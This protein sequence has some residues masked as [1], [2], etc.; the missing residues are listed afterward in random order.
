MMTS[1]RRLNLAAGSVFRTGRR[2]WET[3]KRW[4]IVA[5]STTAVLVAG[6]LASHPHH[7][8]TKTDFASG[9][10]WLPSE[11]PGQLTLLDGST[12]MIAD[13]LTSS[14]IPGTRPGDDLEVAQDGAGAY[15][16]DGAAGVIVRVD[17]TTH[18]A[19]SATSVIAPGTQAVSLY[20][21]GRY[22]YVVDETRDRVVVLNAATLREL[23]SSRARVPRAAAVV[24]GSGRL[25]LFD[26]FTGRVVELSGTHV[27]RTSLLTSP[28]DRVALA[29][30]G[31]RPAVIDYSAPH[32]YVRIA[33]ADPSGTTG[34]R[35]CIDVAAGDPSALTGGSDS[36]R[37]SVVSGTTGLIEETN[38]ANGDCSRSTTLGLAASTPTGFTPP[39][40]TA[41]RVFMG[42]EDTGQVI[43]MDPTTLQPVAPPALAVTPHS[44][45]DV[46]AKDGIVF[47]NDPGS[48]DA[49]VIR[50]D[51]TVIRV[52]KYATRGGHPGTTIVTPRIS[53]GPA[54]PRAGATSGPTVPISPARPQPQGLSPV[55]SNT[56][57][58]V[59]GSSPSHESSNARPDVT[60]IAPDSG[61]AR[62]GNTV[63]IEGVH[64]TAVRSVSFGAIPAGGLHVLSDTALQVAAPPGNVGATVDVTVASAAGSSP[65]GPFDRYTYIADAAPTVTGVS[66]H[67]GLATGGELLVITGTGLAGTTGVHFGQVSA[68]SVTR[69]TDGSLLVTTPAAP[70]GTVDVTV[71]T[72]SGTS[73]PNEADRYTFVQGLSVSRPPM[74]T[75]HIDNQTEPGMMTVDAS[76]DIF[77]AV[78]KGAPHGPDVVLM[79]RPQD[80]KFSVYVAAG[81]V[82]DP[83]GLAVDSSGNLYIADSADHFIRKVDHTTK[84][85]STVAGDG[86]PGIAGMGGPATNAAIGKVVGLA[87]GP[88]G[89]LYL[90]SSFY[91]VVC[92]IQAVDGSIGPDSKISLYAGTPWTPPSMAAGTQSP[93]GSFGDGG[94]ATHAILWNPRGLAVDS[95]GNLYIADDFH[96]RV[97]EV[98][99]PSDGQIIE[100]LAGG[101]AS[102][103]RPQPQNAE[104]VSLEHVSDVA[105]DPFGNLYIA[106]DEVPE[107]DMLTPSG[108]IFSVIG[109]AL[110]NGAGLERTTLA[111]I[112]G[113]AFVPSSEVDAPAGGTLY[114]WEHLAGRVNIF[115]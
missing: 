63:V 70:I 55:R 53:T 56:G 23:G 25:W 27:H 48:P 37:L 14:E 85:I 52:A 29:L 75:K 32:P 82:G 71:T 104:S 68:P 22:L 95:A 78:S 79:K 5:V 94:P 26:Q 76:G 41:G 59:V 18:R 3:P 100:T 8:P 17:G 107:I 1:L 44:Q 83:A 102:P 87:F 72:P 16:A 98:T 50:A 103:V 21:G 111:G 19:V 6:G 77:V 96:G 12:G 31:G 106:D 69:E 60:A 46:F 108:E 74:L 4:W 51:G 88:D 101:G 115:T 91:S 112:G 54:Q 66:G 62:G 92:K 20:S 93:P 2:A 58:G 39:I 43:V 86:A 42:D 24:D 67:T 35:S 33:G 57:L 89:S 97:R 61:P 84:A 109:G 40:E 65:T 110:H 49:G 73:P 9:T 45:F 80:P 30:V 7:S 105:L 15:L 113:I 114:V 90:S 28:G 36:V 47:F 38:T 11:V 13:Q 64:L 81:V 99:P 10:V 34:R